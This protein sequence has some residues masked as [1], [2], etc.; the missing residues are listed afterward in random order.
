[1]PVSNCLDFSPCVVRFVSPGCFLLGQYLSSSPSSS[2]HFYATTTTGTQCW[3]DWGE[4]MS[5][6]AGGIGFTGKCNLTQLRRFMGHVVI[7]YGSF[8]SPNSY[9]ILRLAACLFQALHLLWIL[10]L[11][12]NVQCFRIQW[13]L[14]NMYALSAIVEILTLND[15]CRFP[16]SCTGAVKWLYLWES[17][18]HKF[19]KI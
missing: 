4:C 19:L 2:P 9:V 6:F 12:L 8:L 5:S 17:G 1:M 13:V 3:W 10:H 14:I 11:L 16:Q 18:F 15:H 7:F